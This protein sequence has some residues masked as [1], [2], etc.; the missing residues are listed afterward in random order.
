[1]RDVVSRLNRALPQ[2]KSA[3]KVPPPHSLQA[4]YIPLIMA[5]EIES[6]ISIAFLKR[7]VNIS[8]PYRPAS[9][10]PWVYYDIYKYFDILFSSTVQPDIAALV[11]R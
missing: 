5:D 7:E 6:S 1:M 2:S 3:R 9:A 11:G 8:M 4:Y 10:M